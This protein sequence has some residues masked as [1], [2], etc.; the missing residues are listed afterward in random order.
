MINTQHVV[1]AWRQA[2][3]SLN[4]DDPEQAQQRYGA[5]SGGAERQLAGAVRVV[6]QDQVQLALR[7]AKQFSVPLHPISTGRNWGYGTSLPVHQDCAI[8]DLGGMNRILHFD[9]PFGVVTLEPGV[10]QG[11]LAD[12]LDQ[13]QLPYLV[14]VTGAGPTCSV[15]ANALERGYGVTPH[16][17]HFAA[18]TDLEAVL[19]DGSLY[20]G[21]LA[22]AAGSAGDLL[23]RLFRWNLGPYAHG[24]FTQSGMGVVTRVSIALAPRPEC[25]M[26]CLFAVTKDERLE[27]TVN[28]IRMAM[29]RLHPTLAAVNL[30]NQHRVLSMSAPYP[31]EG[32]LDERGL[33]PPDLLEQMGRRYQATPWTGFATL[34]GTHSMVRAAKGELKRILAGTASRML[35]FT[36][37]RARQLAQ[38]AGWLPA[39]W[40]GGIQSMTSTLAHSLELVAGRPNETA[41]PLAYWRNPGYNHEAGKPRDPAKNGCGLRWYAP[42]VPMQGQTV[43]NY[44]NFVHRVTRQHHLEPLITFTTLGDKVFDST[45]PLVFNKAL[46]GAVENAHAGYETL[47]RQGRDLG[48]FPYRFS[49]D[50]MHWLREL[51]PNA[52]GFAQRLHEVHDPS[53]LLAPGRYR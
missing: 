48:F 25:I 14:P 41:M 2:L 1:T 13:H 44:V 21:M 50:A 31:S 8:L 7:I 43:R 22:E 36:P 28:A 35:F 30:M 17:D 40:A 20:R 46:P 33:I 10:T 49:I 53:N 39:R 5:D 9:E 29:R 42:L 34:Y 52:T 24:L 16:T 6:N 51:A 26:T 27:P 12:Y 18:V 38:V 45:V 37:Q 3:G 11:Q 15:L 47:V 23:P 19:P 32:Q 4:V